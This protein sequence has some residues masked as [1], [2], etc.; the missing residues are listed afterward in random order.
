MGK[1]EPDFMTSYKL[2]LAMAAQTG[3]L[4]FYK[5]LEHCF[6]LILESYIFNGAS[7][8]GNFGKSLPGR[9]QARS[10]WFSTA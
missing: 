6:V 10:F 2:A 9:I 1:R 3:Q 4:Q 5:L 7:T 8:E